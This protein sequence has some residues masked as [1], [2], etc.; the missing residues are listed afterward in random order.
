MLFIKNCTR[1]E[2]NQIK[3]RLS[4]GENNCSV[5]LEIDDNNKIDLLTVA[6]GGDENDGFVDNVYKTIERSFSNISTT[7]TLV[8][9][10]FRKAK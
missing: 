6:N 8:C 1:L 10:T 4:K 2:G 9:L 7:L 5:S 3:V